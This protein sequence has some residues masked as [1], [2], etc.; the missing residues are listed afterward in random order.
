M[1]LAIKESLKPEEIKKMQEAAA[2][3]QKPPASAVTDLLNLDVVPSQRAQ[4]PAAHSSFDPWGTGGK[5]D[6]KNKL[7]GKN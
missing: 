2:A 7:F 5:I 6:L 1:E 4:P 3:A